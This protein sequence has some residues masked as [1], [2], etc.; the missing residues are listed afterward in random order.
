MKVPLFSRNPQ[1]VRVKYV[2]VLVDHLPDEYKNLPAVCHRHGLDVPM[3]FAGFE[4]TPKGNRCAKYRC[5]LCNRIE[6][7]VRDFVSGKPRLLFSRG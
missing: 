4:K 7:Y 2:P 3:R 6:M 5:P 1:P